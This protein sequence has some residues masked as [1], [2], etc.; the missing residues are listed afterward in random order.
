MAMMRSSA[1]TQDGGQIL[2]LAQG[3]MLIRVILDPRLAAP[4]RFPLSAAAR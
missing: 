4:V 2:S 3:A 1:L